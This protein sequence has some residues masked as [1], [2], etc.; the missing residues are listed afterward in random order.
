MMG[1]LYIVVLNV[2]PGL[3]VVDV[4][5][6][7]EGLAWFRISPNVWVVQLEVGTSISVLNDALVGLVQPSGSLFI[8]KL[9]IRE[10]QGWMGQQFWDWINARARRWA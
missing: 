10:R 1:G 2:N 3:T 6:R 4:Q 7:I 5:Q 9:D 8:S